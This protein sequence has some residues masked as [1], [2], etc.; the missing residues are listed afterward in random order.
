VSRRRTTYRLALSLDEK[1]RVQAIERPP[2]A[3]MHAQHPAHKRGI[4]GSLDLDV[5]IGLKPRPAGGERRYS[6]RRGR[7]GYPT[8]V[9]TLGSCRDLRDPRSA[10][11]DY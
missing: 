6:R 11:S 4:S 8:M 10:A 3:L 2:A 7:P 1:T 5:N 9:Q